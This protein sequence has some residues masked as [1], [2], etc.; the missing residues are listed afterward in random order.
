[1]RIV[2]VNPRSEIRNKAKWL[3]VDD[4]KDRCKEGFLRRAGWKEKELER[5]EV[6]V[7]Y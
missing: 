7:D 5:H 6:A 2:L 3:E 4:Y 1:M